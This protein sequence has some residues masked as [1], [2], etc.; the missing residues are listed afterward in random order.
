MTG[1]EIK[2]MIEGLIDD[3][4]DDTEFVNLMNAVEGLIAGERHWKKLTAID[5]SKTWTSS[6]SYTSTKA[7]PTD[8]F[9]PI[10]LYV[11]GEQRPWPA[12]AFEDRERYKDIFGRWYIDYANDVF[13]LCGVTGSTRT[14]YLAYIKTVT[15]WTIANY[16]S[17]SPWMPARF[18]PLWAYYG[19][20]IHLGG[21][22]ADDLASK[23]AAVHAD[24]FRAFRKMAIAW[25]SRLKAHAMNYSARQPNIIPGTRSDVVGEGEIY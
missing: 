13:G 22:D 14:L 17:Q 11:Q 5:S 18:H 10:K 1:D 25:D 2:T 9:E 15:V 20:G 16:T 12:I 3:D 4:L 21:V 19:A 23:M 7:L 8:F 6:D 24:Q